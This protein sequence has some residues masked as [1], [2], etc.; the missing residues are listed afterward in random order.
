MSLS[1][2]IS[3]SRLS[4][5]TLSSQ[6]LINATGVADAAIAIL[7]D[8][9]EGEKA[10]QKTFEEMISKK[11]R[12]PR[13]I[14]AIQEQLYAARDRRL[15]DIEPSKRLGALQAFSKFMERFSQNAAYMNRDIWWS[16]DMNAIRNINAAQVAWVKTT[17][18]W[19]IKNHHPTQAA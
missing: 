16:D 17:Y 5:W 19:I 2:V 4:E 6:A 14:M 15:V 3:E 13:D 12:D 1:N 8:N 18:A 10:I 11:L 9:P 7:Q